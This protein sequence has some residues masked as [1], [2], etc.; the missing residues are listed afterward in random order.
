[1]KPI[2]ACNA[3]IWIEG[4]FEDSDVTLTRRSGQVENLGDDLYSRQPICG[5]DG[6]GGHFLVVYLSGIDLREHMRNNGRP[7]ARRPAAPPPGNAVLIKTVIN[8][9]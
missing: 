3:A 1:M 7:S 4:V 9:R 6:T 2:R 8:L 5:G